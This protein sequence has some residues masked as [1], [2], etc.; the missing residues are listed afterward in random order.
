MWDPGLW[1]TFGER[2]AASK[3]TKGDRVTHEPIDAQT[4]E[5]ATQADLVFHM[6]EPTDPK[7]APHVL[8]ARNTAVMPNS[9]LR[10]MVYPD[11]SPSKVKARV[12]LTDVR[13]WPYTRKIRR[14]E[15]LVY[16]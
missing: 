13:I 4:E 7:E 1:G 16:V 3:E 14:Y 11:R 6:G 12:N 9:L 10:L 8:H 15:E 5:A 2:G